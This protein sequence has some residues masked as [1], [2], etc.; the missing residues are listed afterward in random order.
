MM[1]ELQSQGCHNI[2]FVSPS[3]FAAQIAMA[4]DIAA[5]KGL[6]IPLVYNT[7]GYDSLDTLRLSGGD[8]KYIP[9]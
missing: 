9:P 8:N 7:N 1:L 3:H 5:S 4:V 2:N 6:R